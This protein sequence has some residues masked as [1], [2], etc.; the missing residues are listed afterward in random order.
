MIIKDNNIWSHDIHIFICKLDE[1]GLKQTLCNVNVTY[2]FIEILILNY[3]IH[4]LRVLIFA[5]HFICFF[6]RL[7]NIHSL[8]FNHRPSMCSMYK[9]YIL[10]LVVGIVAIYC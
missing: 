2:V 8:P 1:S 4:I 3:K 5:K 10:L 6:L 7:F 9:M